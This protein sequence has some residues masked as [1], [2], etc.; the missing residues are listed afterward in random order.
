MSKF[1]LEIPDIQGYGV[2]YYF[3]EGQNEYPARV[4]PF[5]LHDQ[6]ELYILIEGDVSFAV[7]SSLYRLSPCDAIVTK[8][9]EM[10][11]CILNEHSVHKHLCFW[12]EP[13]AAFLFEDFLA[14]D[15][16]KG[17]HIVLDGVR[18]EELLALIPKLR[19]ASEKGDR[20]AQFYLT[21][22]LLHLYRCFSPMG[23][24]AVS[25]PP[26][27]CEILSFVDAHFK[28]VGTVSELA[29]KYYISNSTLTRLFR[30]HLHTSPKKYLETK[31]L[32]H[33]RLLLR[34]GYSVLDACMESGFSDY[35]NY[36][37]LFKNRFGI[38][39]GEYRTEKK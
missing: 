9:N 25:M 22:E 38:T 39:P 26:L 13:S 16:G 14:H 23:A 20:H 36:I 5:H 32:A 2:E 12:F 27:L 7:E 35:S 15:F 29:E 19:A 1:H 31:R 33:S 10:H 30:T 11:N 24:H 3:A 18:K 6:I 17:N 4:F 34:K 37:R 21:L 28:S 8:P